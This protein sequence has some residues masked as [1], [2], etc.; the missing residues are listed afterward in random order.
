MPWQMV[1]WIR[2]HDPAQPHDPE[3]PCNHA[4]DRRYFLLFDHGCYR[5][6]GGTQH[7]RAAGIMGAVYGADGAGRFPGPTTPQTGSAD[8]LSGPAVPA[9]YPADERDRVLFHRAQ[10][11]PPD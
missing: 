7:R 4:D 10:L 3:K 8:T 5:Q 6:G 9:L 11:D 2:L 1:A